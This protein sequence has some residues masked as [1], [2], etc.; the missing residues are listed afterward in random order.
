MDRDATAVDRELFSQLVEPPIKPVNPSLINISF[1]R[2]HGRDVY[3]IKINGVA[4]MEWAT[5]RSSITMAAALN[6]SLKQHG[7]VLK[8]LCFEKMGKNLPSLAGKG[9]GKGHHKWL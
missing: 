9:K 5:L 8:S 3:L 4:L 7:Y 1:E 2:F 6:N